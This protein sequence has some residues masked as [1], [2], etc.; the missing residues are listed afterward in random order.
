MPIALGKVWQFWCQSRTQRKD[1]LGVQYVTYGKDLIFFFPPQAFSA[2][3]GCVCGGQPQGVLIKP[4]IRVGMGRHCIGSAHES[5]SWSQPPSLWDWGQDDHQAGVTPQGTW[6]LLWPWPME[7]LPGEW[8]GLEWDSSWWMCL[9]S[10]RAAGRAAGDVH[11]SGRCSLSILHIILAASIQHRIQNSFGNNFSLWNNSSGRRSMSYFFPPP[12][13][14]LVCGCVSDA[15]GCGMGD[16]PL[17]QTGTW[18]E[19]SVRI[20]PLPL[21]GWC[22]YG[23]VFTLGR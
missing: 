11:P 12:H 22:L 7:P 5:Q 17:A 2:M 23:H 19:R 20:W 18:Q 8:E 3:F 21:A 13:A 4:F 10:W 16:S 15:N 14:T 6:S 1:S 9:G